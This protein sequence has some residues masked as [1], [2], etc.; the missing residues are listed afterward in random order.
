LHYPSIPAAAGYAG[1]LG[2]QTDMGTVTRSI[3]GAAVAASSV[4]TLVAQRVS[5]PGDDGLLELTQRAARESPLGDLS[6]A[7]TDGAD[8]ELRFWAGYGTEGTH[9]LILQRQGGAWTSY[10]AT[11]EDC[12][13]LVPPSRG[14]LTDA[15]LAAYEQQALKRCNRRRLAVKEGYQIVTAHRLRLRPVRLEGDLDGLWRELFSS[16][17]ADLPPKVQRESI[18]LD[19]QTFVV[20]H[21]TGDEY[22]AS[23]IE[24][25]KPEGL[26]DTQVQRIATLLFNRLPTAS[27]LQCIYQ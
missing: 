26:V 10:V 20:E 14:Q 4:V 5:A 21:R 6:R 1:A 19:G 2:G 12:H 8:V 7:R 17:L 15:Q 3:I 13:V 27:W 11:I 18:M 22:R 24:C 9:G 23:V 25:I 16:G